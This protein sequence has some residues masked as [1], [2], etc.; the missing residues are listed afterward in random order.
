MLGFERKE[1]FVVKGG[2]AKQIRKQLWRIAT[3]NYNEKDLEHIHDL[4]VTPTCELV[5]ETGNNTISN[6][7]RVCDLRRDKTCEGKQTCCDKFINHYDA[8]T[9]QFCKFAEPGEDDK[10]VFCPKK[11]ETK[12][13]KCWCVEFEKKIE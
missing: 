12:N 9:C 13:N 4:N 5:D 1:R 6:I 11:N 3:G 7:C 8:E 10:H 2:M